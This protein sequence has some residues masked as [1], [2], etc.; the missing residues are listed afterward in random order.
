MILSDADPMP[1][2]GLKLLSVIVERNSAFIVILSK[3]NL[4]EVIFQYFEIN[5]PKFNAFT[6][7]IVRA[8]IQS[9]EIDLADLIALGVVDKMNGIFENVMRNNQEWCTDHLLEIINEILHM[10]SEIKKK[11]KSEGASEAKAIDLPANDA[12]EQTFPQLIFDSFLS[13]Y[14]HFIVLLT[15]SDAAIVERAAQNILAFIHFSMIQGISRNPL[16]TLKEEQL[17]YILPAFNSDKTS[18]CKNLIKSIYWA[19]SLNKNAL[20]PSPDNAKKI[21]KIAEKLLS[22]DD[23]SL[24]NTAREVVK[25]CKNLLA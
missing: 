19:L 12:Q 22:S 4:I 5:H 1:L 7:K 16:L 2:F 24:T 14:E 20:R 11:Q 25:L 17:Q 21:M 8:I 23:K 15:A 10:A 9:R 18:V 3:L 6:I 13:N